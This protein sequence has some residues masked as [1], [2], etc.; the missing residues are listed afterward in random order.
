MCYYSPAKKCKL[1]SPWIGPYLIVSFMGWTI[2][3]QKEPES[4]VVMV[5]CQDAKKI[6]PPL[7]EVSWLTSKESTLKPAVTVLGASTMH[8][9]MP[10]YIS[11]TMGLSVEHMAVAGE[12]SSC[13]VGPLI[14]P[15]SLSQL[16]VTSATRISVSPRLESD[17]A[18]LDLSCVLHPFFVHRMDSGPVRLSPKS[19]NNINMA[20]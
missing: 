14:H 12:D 5:H 18:E 17:T 2:G 20:M 13:A 4:P 8:R 7:G 15:S 19:I 10:N 16:D 6:P 1:D 9:T 11:M 3:I